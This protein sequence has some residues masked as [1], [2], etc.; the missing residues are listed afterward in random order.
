MCTIRAKFLERL[1]SDGAD[2]FFHVYIPVATVHAC[3]QLQMHSQEKNAKNNFKKIVQI[4]KQ[5]KSS[6]TLKVPSETWGEAAQSIFAE[7]DPVHSKLV[8]GIITRAKTKRGRDGDIDLR[9]QIF[10]VKFNELNA[11][12][13][14]DLEYVLSYSNLNEEDGSLLR[15]ALKAQV[16][17]ERVQKERKM[18]AKGE[19][20]ILMMGHHLQLEL[21]RSPCCTAES[22][23][24]S[25]SKK[26]KIQVAKEPI[27]VEKVTPSVDSKLCDPE[28]VSSEKPAST[29]EVESSGT[30]AFFVCDSRHQGYML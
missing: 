9:G 21:Y 11:S 24:A 4:F 26:A 10:T 6:C 28:D 8:E 29:E 17:N 18:K 12:Y 19:K 30:K 3:C 23:G 1:T 5:L 15:D 25:R 13:P 16:E 22:Q 14:V 7:L 2:N 20:L 27:G